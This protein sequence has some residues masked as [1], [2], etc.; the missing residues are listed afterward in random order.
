MSK[1]AF[2]LN[3][4]I[5]ND[6]YFDNM[7]KYDNRWTIYFG[8]AGSGKSYAI[9]QKLILK[10]MKEPRRVLVCRRFGK[11]LRDSVFQN[12][13]DMLATFQLID[14]CRIIE[15]NF[16]IEL[17]NG[18][19]FIFRG[20]DDE[21]KL[22]SIQDISDVWVEEATEASK[23]LLLQ[24]SLRMRGNA[25]NHQIHLSFNPV[26]TLNYLYDFI[27]NPPDGLIVIHST[28][29][30]N[31]FLPESYVKALEDMY[32][33]DPQKARVYCDGD[34]GVMG[35][36]V[37]EHNWSVQEF[38]VSDLIKQGLEPRFG[39]DFGFTLDPTGI[40]AT[41][42]DKNN[43]RIYVFD[44][45]YEKG[46]TN[47]ELAKAITQKRFHK[48]KIW[49]DSSD[50]KSITELQR[51]NIRAVPAKKGHDSI[52]FGISFINAHKL[53]IHPRCKEHINEIKG[54]QH[55]KDKNTGQYL[56]EKL[57]GADHVMDSLRYAYSEIYTQARFR[58][59]SKGCFGL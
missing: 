10:A 35:K 42:Y 13:K 27:K 31:K 3:R 17:P 28:Y 21:S 29:K 24:L 20:L 2:K 40:S 7:F 34:W 48:Q 37:Y 44:E 14:H 50:P 6:K 11:D 49:F 47:P 54:Y 9:A 16:R 52:Q 39:G 23:D 4:N 57:E 56:M 41:L 53:I 25:E 22:L 38:S 30:D 19:L 45:L 58:S 59:L 43:K 26:S 18:S 1:V 46:L 51:L 12:V 15:S 8:S 55:K 36:L 33:L 5:F 32:V